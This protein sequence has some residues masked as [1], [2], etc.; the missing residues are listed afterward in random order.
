MNR[1]RLGRILLAIILLALLAAAVAVW[2]FARQV[3]F[4]GAFGSGGQATLSAPPGFEVSVFA[5]GLQ[6]PRFIAFS[7][8]GDLLVAERGAGRI[9]VLPDANGDGAADRVQVFADGLGAPHSLAFADGSWFVGIPNGVLRL[10]DLDDD[11][12]AD[13]QLTLIDSYPTG[14][15]NTRT[16]LFLPDGRMV[17]SI[18]SSCNVCEEADPRRA[19]IVVYD[20]PQATGEAIFATGLRNAV[21]LAI[22]PATGDLWATNNGRD[23]LGDDLPPDAV[24]VVREGVDYGWPRCNSG[25]LVD[26]DFGFE[27]A[28]DGVPDPAVRIQAHSAPLGLAFY[29][30]EA[31]PESYRG[32]LFVAY[33]GSWNRSEPTGYTVVYVP[34][35]A[36]GLAGEPQDFIVGWLDPAADDIAGRPVGLAVGPDGALYISDDKGGFIYRAIYRGE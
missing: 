3:N 23:F 2:R 5:A 22:H 33:H 15:H 20:G 14:G 18:G 36:A 9:V 4:T 8:Q 27:G 1:R 10:T 7:P 13:E 25:R 21:G 29:D 31:F 35:T 16:V 12:R 6:G 24:Y 30:A 34:V 26:P 32:G 17:V 19:G 28:C 11:Q